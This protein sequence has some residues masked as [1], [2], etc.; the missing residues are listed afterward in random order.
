MHLKS[1]RIKYACKKIKVHL[2]IDI[3]VIIQDS[4]KIDSNINYHLSHYQILISYNSPQ[5]WSYIQLFI[6]CILYSNV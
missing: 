5:Y 3:K 6:N 2:Y 1:I 4:G